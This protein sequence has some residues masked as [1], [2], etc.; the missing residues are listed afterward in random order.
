MYESTNDPRMARGGGGLRVSGGVL[1]LVL[2]AH[3]CDT[4]GA[5]CAKGQIDR[6]TISAGMVATI[7]DGV[8]EVYVP[9]QVAVPPVEGDTGGDAVLEAELATA[10]SLVVSSNYTGV[11]ADLMS[12]TIVES[13]PAAPGEWSWE[14]D[15]DRDLATMTFFATAPGGLT[16]KTDVEYDAMLSIAPN[17][18]IEAEE[19]FAFTVSVVAE[20]PED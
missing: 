13:N 5:I 17:D 20:K 7:S 6:A 1:G 2:V 11:T 10:V 18:Y 12:G 19:A 15:D 9:F 14:L 16:L 4:P 8:G 3:G